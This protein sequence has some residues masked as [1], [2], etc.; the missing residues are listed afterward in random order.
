MNTGLFAM[1]VLLIILVG[2]LGLFSI[3]G[4]Y[5]QDELKDD[6]N[7]ILLVA[8]FIDVCCIIVEAFVEYG[9]PTYAVVIAVPIL[10]LIA[11]NL[12]RNSN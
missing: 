11:Y 6:I 9:A 2:L 4:E 12:G 10:V 8:L 5:V 3:V 1:I 7:D